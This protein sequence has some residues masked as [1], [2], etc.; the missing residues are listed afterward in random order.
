[1]VLAGRKGQPDA[2]VHFTDSLNRGSYVD[3]TWIFAEKTII[4]S[5]NPRQN[6]R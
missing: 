6:P 5:Q 3:M 4:F 2:S 1:M